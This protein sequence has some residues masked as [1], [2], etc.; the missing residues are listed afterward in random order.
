MAYKLLQ[1]AIGHSH[2]INNDKSLSTVHHWHILIAANIMIIISQ[3]CF[4]DV[5]AKDSEKA[6]LP[7]GC[8]II[9]AISQDQYRC[10]QALRTILLKHG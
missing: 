7:T 9:D 5:C 1:A 6:D 4:Y 3:C 2:G 10:C 8:L